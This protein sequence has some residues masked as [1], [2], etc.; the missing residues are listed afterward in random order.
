MASGNAHRMHAAACICPLEPRV[1]LRPLN[2]GQRAGQSLVDE[3]A[4]VEAALFGPSGRTCWLRDS[5]PSWESVSGNVLSSRPRGDRLSGG[6]ARLPGACSQE[7]TRG[8]GRTSPISPRG[9]AARPNPTTGA[10]IPLLESGCPPTGVGLITLLVRVRTLLEHS[11]REE[12]CGRWRHR[13]GRAP[14]REH[15]RHRIVPRAAFAKGE[16][17]D[18][19]PAG[20][21]PERERGSPAGRRTRA[22]PSRFCHGPRCCDGVTLGKAQDLPVAPVRE[23]PAKAG[24][25]VRNVAV[26]PSGATRMASDHRP[27]RRYRKVGSPHGTRPRQS[28]STRPRGRMCSGRIAPGQRALSVTGRSPP[29]PAAPPQGGQVWGGKPGDP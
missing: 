7:P 28:R 22:G 4:G 6:A 16:D 15:R 26:S 5:L 19:S 27:T 17:R 23:T 21:T 20:T 24:S 12:R 2:K 9:V 29:T 3:P 1:H 14:S 13:R 10:V 8:Q 18:R 25:C 11:S